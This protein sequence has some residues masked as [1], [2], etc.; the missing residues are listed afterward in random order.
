MHLFLCGVLQ[1]DASSVQ[2]EERLLNLH[3][4]QNETKLNKIATVGELRREKVKGV[5]LT[6]IK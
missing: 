4:V 6:T 1:V 5:W 3:H 2:D